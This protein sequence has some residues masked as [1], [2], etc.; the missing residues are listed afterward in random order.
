M[1]IWSQHSMMFFWQRERLQHE[2]FKVRRFDVRG[3][4][5][6]TVARCL[7]LRRHSVIRERKTVKRCWSIETT[8]QWMSW[9]KAERMSNNNRGL[10]SLWKY[11]DTPTATIKQHMLTFHFIILSLFHCHCHVQQITAYHCLIKSA[12]KFVKVQLH[13][14]ALCC[15]DG[16]KFWSQILFFS[17]F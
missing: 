2:S 8:N 5:V 10:C 13:V 11:A 15:L 6:S 16:C 7:W 12:S 4:Y 9:Q 14:K 1:G 17:F 3:S